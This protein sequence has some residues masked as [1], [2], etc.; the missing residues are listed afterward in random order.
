MIYNCN[1]CP[2]N[3][4]VN[5]KN[6]LGFCKAK[7]TLKVALVSLHKYEEPCISVKEGSGTIFFSH[8]NMRCVYCQN[9]DIS[10]KGFG[11]EITINRLKEIFLEQMGRGAKNIN[12]VSPSIYVDK[13]KKAIIMAKKE[14]LNIPIIYNTNG[15]DKV[16]TLKSLD[17]LIDV[18]LPDFKYATNEIGVK[19]SKTNNYFDNVVLAL[20]EMKRQCPKEIFLKDGSIQKGMIIRHLILPGEIKNSKEVFKWI[21]E[22]FGSKQY[23]SVMA[24]YF[25]TYNAN[26]YENLNRKIT[27]EELEDIT[28]YIEELGFENGYIQELGDHEEEYVPKFNLKNV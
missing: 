9:Y 8:C 7:D 6:I 16:E 26:E 22:N 19:Y 10:Q 17:G 15:Y 13:I 4:N 27:K 18:Y 25:P 3:C 28:N 2:N 24:Q 23:I 20:K 12:L 1:T 14:G 21:K 5:R 11:K